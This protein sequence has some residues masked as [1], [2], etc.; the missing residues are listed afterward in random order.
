MKTLLSLAIILT[1]LSLPVISAE[2]INSADDYAVEVVLNKPG[3]GYDLTKLDNAKNI[4]ISNNQYILRSDYSSSLATILEKSSDLQCNSLP[5]LSVRLQI[6]LKAEEKSFPYLRFTSP[7]ITGSLNISEDI[8]N[9]WKVSCVLGNPT[10]QC[11]FKKDKTTIS[12]N[13]AGGKYEITLETKENLKSC[14]LCDGICIGSSEKK[15]IG[16]LLMADVEDILKHSGLI[17]SF[18]QLVTSY[19]RFTTGN[20]IITDLSSET[21]NEVDWSKAISQ[22]LNFLKINNILFITGQDIDQISE[23]AKQGAAGTNSR[24]VFGEDKDGNEKWMY[25]SQTKF[26]SLTKLQNCKELSISQIP[27]GSLSFSG[28]SNLSSYYAIPIAI[29]SSLLI[30][31]FILIVSARLIDSRR[32]RKL[33]PITSIQA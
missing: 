27:A 24:I 31:F 32:K 30:L 11:E 1:L 23:L 17:D 16:K 13:L 6:P 33:K 8:Y 3:I 18:E 14:A 21:T 22:E 2:C 12:A 20:A 29:T 9:D 25:Y 26:P 5:G 15:C 7:P 4:L 19:K 28:S 10:P